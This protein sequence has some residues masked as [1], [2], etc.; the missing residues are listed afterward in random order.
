MDA[1][2]AW[3]RGARAAHRVRERGESHAGTRHR[4]RDRDRHPLRAGCFARGDRADAAR[5]VRPALARGRRPRDPARMARRARRHPVAAIGPSASGHHRDRRAR[6]GRRRGGRA[7]DRRRIRSRA[8]TAVIATEPVDAPQQR[9]FDDG[10]RGEPRPAQ[11]ARRV[12]DRPGGG[13]GGRRRALHRQLRQAHAGRYRL[14][15]Y[16]AARR[17]RGPRGAIRQRGPGLRAG[18]GLHAADAGGRAAR[19][20]SR[21]ASPKRS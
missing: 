10:Q 5:R 16:P 4:A 14:R 11:P 1:D 21:A 17:E 19:C 9:P 18:R 7:R 13:A 12:G 15:L 2:A 8:G 20:R 3:G 6:V